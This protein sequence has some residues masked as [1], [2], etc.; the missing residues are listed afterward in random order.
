MRFSVNVLMPLMCYGYLTLWK[1][2]IGWKYSGF[3]RW[4][5]WKAGETTRI[6]TSNINFDRSKTNK[7]N[8]KNI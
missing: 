1:D 5:G 7:K 2:I 6:F 4:S 3:R 8:K